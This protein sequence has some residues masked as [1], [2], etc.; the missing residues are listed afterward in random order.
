MEWLQ[1]AVRIYDEQNSCIVSSLPE[2]QVS[3]YG[4]ILDA[5]KIRE[6]P[7]HNLIICL[8]LAEKQRE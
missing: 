6:E 3:C 5:G 8:F 1:N 7:W 2:F 4:K